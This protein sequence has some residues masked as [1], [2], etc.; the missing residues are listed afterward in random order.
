MAFNLTA[1]ITARLANGG[2]IATRIRDEL[3]QPFFIDVQFSSNAQKASQKLT[4]NIKGLNVQLKELA[5]NGLTASKAMDFLSRSF[6]SFKGGVNELNKTAAATKRAREETKKAT[7]SVAEFGRVSG[8]ALR[9]N[10]GFLIATGAVYGLGR[11]ITSSFSEAIRFEKE[12]VKVAQVSNRSVASL[13]P[14]TDEITRLSTGL[15]VASSDLVDISLILAQ[16]GLSANETRQ[17]LEALAKTTLAA[18]F[19]DIRDTT[20]GAIALM[21]QFQ[22]SASDLGKALGSTNAVSAAFAVESEDI[23]AAVKR[24]GGVFAQTSAGLKQGPLDTFNQFIATFSAV[25]ATTRESAE[26]IATGIRTI[27]TRIQRPATIQFLRELGIELTDLNGRFVGPFEAVNRLSQGLEN[28]DRRGSSFARV[29]EELGGFRQ[30][31]KTLALLSSSTQ[32]LEA[33]QVAQQ[34]QNS[35]NKDAEQAQQSLANAIAKT[36]EEFTALIREI[37]Q[38]KSFDTIV[39]TV[40]SLANSFIKLADAVKPIIPLLSALAVVKGVSAGISF[41]SSFRKAAVGR[42]FA[43]GGKVSGGN[44]GIDDIPAR[45]TKG[46]YVIN[47]KS[48]AIIG[49]ANLDNLN[50]IGFA[51]GGKVGKKFTNVGNFIG[52]EI[53]IAPIEITLNVRD[54]KGNVVQKNTTSGQ[55][56]SQVFD[57]IFPDQ[58]ESNTTAPI[59]RSVRQS[60]L[61]QGEVKQLKKKLGIPTGPNNTVGNLTGD[62]NSSTIATL[63][64]RQELSLLRDVV[65]PISQETLSPEQL[66][67]RQRL[68]F[69]SITS[70]PESE[71]RFSQTNIDA[72]L[73]NEGRKERNRRFNRRQ[74]QA[75]AIEQARG[76]RRISVRQF[77]QIS[78]PGIQDILS[79]DRSSRF[80][81]TPLNA[82]ELLREEE[83]RF[84]AL[85][86]GS[87]RT[88]DSGTPRGRTNNIRSRLLRF[89]QR[90]VGLPGLA[91]VFGRELFGSRDGAKR[92]FSGAN[93]NINR[94]VGG[95]GL[96][97]G[98]II[99][100]KVGGRAGSAISGATTGAFTGAAIGSAIPG[101]GTAAG[102][103]IGG[104]IGALNAFNQAKLDE[105]IKKSSDEMIKSI[106]NVEKAF[107]KFD[108][109]GP[110]QVLK[111]LPEL[112]KSFDDVARTAG[113]A[114]KADFS[115]E[116]P[117]FISKFGLLGEA[118]FS[119]KTFG[120][121]TREKNNQILDN[122][123]NNAKSNLAPS[124]ENASKLLS[125]LLSQNGTNF[126]QALEKINPN[127]L[128]ALAST[129]VN[130]DTREGRNFAKTLVT[131]DS[132]AIIE[133]SKQQILLNKE[134]FETD[135]KANQLLIEQAKELANINN[136]TDLFIE[137]MKNLSAVLDRASQA[138]ESFRRSNEALL[139]RRNGG[140]GIRSQIRTNVFDNTRAFTEREISNEALRINAF[141]GN[142]ANSREITQGVIGA[143][144]LQSRLPSV[145]NA[146]SGGV[147]SGAEGNVLLPQLINSN[148][149]GLPKVLRD[150]L[151][152][153]IQ[154]KFFAN[155]QASPD[156]I[157][158][159]LASG[160]VSDLQ[161]TAQEVNSIFKKLVDVT[162]QKISEY[163]QVLDQFIQLNQEANQAQDNRLQILND[164]ANQEKQ[165]LG[166]RRLSVADRS[167]GFNIQLG[168]F[169]NRAGSGTSVEQLIARESQLNARREGSFIGAPDEIARQMA[170]LTQQQQDS[171]RALELIV[172]NTDRQNALAE[173]LNGLI[174]SRREARQ[175]FEDF[176]F[177]SPTERR[178]I[179]RNIDL[180][181]RQNEGEDFFG[182][183]LK[184]AREGQR[185]LQALVGATQGQDA[186]KALDQRQIDVLDRSGA[187]RLFGAAGVNP[188]VGVGG[189]LNNRDALF[190]G[191]FQQLQELN[192]QRGAAAA[193]IESINRRDA[194]QF[195]QNGRNAFNSFQSE[196]Q[197]NLAS[198]G[199]LDM[200]N[201]TLANL[202]EVI[203][204]GGSVTHNI[205]FNGLEAFAALEPSV[206]KMIE[207]HV[208]LE[209]NR[210]LNPLTG[211]TGPA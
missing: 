83:A 9:R 111:S 197:S 176:A 6:G 169:A 86:P 59:G 188:G 64:N 67:L 38:T 42:G 44:G 65:S 61:T 66:R 103:A 155:E 23:I 100:D 52:S 160:D 139:S 178:E 157:A 106:T 40:L 21:A 119:S 80:N 50:R 201:N 121:I 28:L 209:I 11:A 153:D 162:N 144:Q 10:T 161:G 206:R 195:E 57:A 75:Q 128:V 15:G 117:S 152:S 84:G 99:G 105:K 79:E 73:A 146:L 130:A 94:F 124:A 110:Q 165:L 101:I 207:Q 186:L 47:R 147:R 156:D 74:A 172:S 190:Q 135:A 196:L 98:I 204:I 120:G 148:F 112:N 187:S 62:I 25:R 104:I 82:A 164:S 88:F 63:R 203:Q 91:P 85:N 107:S 24:A 16:A 159:A 122:I 114:A 168:Q 125:S 89:G 154:T 2:S 13:K 14:L 34:G 39:R 199:L 77:A 71:N 175:V 54:S 55:T 45:L 31:G 97:A 41:A 210:R 43:K 78:Q 180:A 181:R 123:L 179:E 3:K 116:A 141:L 4:D 167:R 72:R 60:K 96:A 173:D 211:E 131:G 81:S 145:L 7:D 70:L 56:G 149:G 202:P 150:K 18:T 69:E 118:A 138:G 90:T 182:T 126:N 166:Q 183:N 37:A 198:G 194:N 174:D 115:N 29:A 53:E 68:N 108:S 58:N 92:L 127:A 5:L 27:F 191:Q 192:R 129:T 200:L 205:N 140:A 158:N 35:V 109:L 33:L 177:G 143:K 193:G 185:A 51:K 170:L 132:K 134:K 19:G 76:V 48:A 49:D 137:R 171:L 95:G 208:N 133:A 12:L 46:E 163:E 142:N 8:L 20:E 189:L 87:P 32:R 30:I 102:A 151:Q 17:A 184:R 136:Q 1:N 36:R 93:R 113:N 22:I 26:S